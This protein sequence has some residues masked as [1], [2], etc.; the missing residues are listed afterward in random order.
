LALEYLAEVPGGLMAGDLN[1]NP[2]T[3]ATL[4]V[5]AENARSELEGMPPGM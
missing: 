2:N 3:I 5:L 4:G 1:V